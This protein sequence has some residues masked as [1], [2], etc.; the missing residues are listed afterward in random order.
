LAASSA[1]QQVAASHGVTIFQILL[2]WTM[3]T[4]DVL[5]IPKATGIA[6]VEANAQA[7]QIIFTPEDLALL[8]G[9]FPR[10]NVNNLWILSELIIRDRDLF[11][12]NKYANKHQ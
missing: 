7:A 6:H 10:G 11:E 3:R 8:G 2:A 4:V 1:L 12:H 9:V 5:T